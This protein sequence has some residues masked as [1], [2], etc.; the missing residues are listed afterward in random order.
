[1]IERLQDHALK[2]VYGTDKSARRLRGL[3][4]IGTLRERREELCRK[5]ANKCVRDPVF[6][7]WFPL[8]TTR[9]SGRTG[10]N[11]L[12]LEEN[13]RCERLK[14]S[15]IYYFRRLLNGKEGKRIGMRN[16]EYRQDII[17]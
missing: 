4:G 14:N 13:A 5:F 1:M 2:C 6:E 16:K 7:K 8:R 17:V 15:P 9:R 10:G 11:E 3:A 12:Y